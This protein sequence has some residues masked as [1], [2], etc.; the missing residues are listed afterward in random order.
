MAAREQRG[1]DQHDRDLRSPTG[2]EQLAEALEQKAAVEGLLAEP[3][4]DDDGEEDVRGAAALP[5]M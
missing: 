4:A 1:R 2:A 3:A 5:A